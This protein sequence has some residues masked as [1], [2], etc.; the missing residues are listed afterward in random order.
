MMYE[1]TYQVGGEE[2]M[3]RVE[4]PDAASAAAMVRDS[5]VRAS[6]RFELLLVQLVD[7]APEAAST[8]TNEDDGLSA[9]V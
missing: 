7:R 9:S 1:V 6:E 2:H 5:H 4:A 8:S 3:D